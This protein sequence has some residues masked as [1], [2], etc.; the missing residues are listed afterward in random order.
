MFVKMSKYCD[1]HVWFIHVIRYTNEFLFVTTAVHT[2]RVG[3]CVKKNFP[4]RL[5]IL[6]LC[7]ILIKKLNNRTNKKNYSKLLSTCFMLLSL[8]GSS[9]NYFIIRFPSLGGLSKL[10][11]RL[12]LTLSHRFCLREFVNA[13]I[14]RRK[15]YFLFSYISVC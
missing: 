13:A 12:R 4:M 3:S 5:F 6:I 7:T 1:T 10:K 8:V 15:K 9:D 2:L 14:F 11:F